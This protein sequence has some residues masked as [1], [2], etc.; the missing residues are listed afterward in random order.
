MGVGSGIRE[1]VDNRIE[2]KELVETP[3]AT[4]IYLQTVYPH[5]PEDTELEGALEG[6]KNL[7]IVVE[8]ALGERILIDLHRFQKQSVAATCLST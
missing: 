1:G 8:F 4:Y 2:L 5:P 6:Y 7:Y 3:S